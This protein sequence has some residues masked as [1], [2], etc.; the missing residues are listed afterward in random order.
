MPSGCT[1]WRAVCA[2]EACAAERA[3][4]GRM[5]N[6]SESLSEGDRGPTPTSRRAGG[7]PMLAEDEDVPELGEAEELH[8]A[9]EAEAGRAPSRSPTPAADDGELQ[10]CAAERV[11]GDALPCESRD[12][13]WPLS[14]LASPRLPLPLLSSPRL[15]SPRLA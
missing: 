8:V 14:G 1:R 12:K 10:A 13:R 2:A 15:A 7:M 4:T 9:A 6:L 5:S 11:S 3:R